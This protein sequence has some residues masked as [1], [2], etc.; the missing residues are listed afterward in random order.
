MTRA[1]DYVDLTKMTL[2]GHDAPKS[3]SSSCGGH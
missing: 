3:T 1:R 2:N